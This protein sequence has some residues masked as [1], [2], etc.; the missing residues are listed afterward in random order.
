MPYP[1]ACQ[2][3]CTLE[4]K[5]K[6]KHT[7]LCSWSWLGVGLGDDLQLLHKPTDHCRHQPLW[8]TQGKEKQSPEEGLALGIQVLTLSSPSCCWLSSASSAC[9]HPRMAIVEPQ[10][11]PNHNVC[12]KMKEMLVH[13]FL[14]YFF[15]KIRSG[16]SPLL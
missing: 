15:F 5:T 14:F 11:Y 2:L 7:F 4:S 10:E 6:L 9:T 13:F 12:V 1:A 16:D 8:S 3:C